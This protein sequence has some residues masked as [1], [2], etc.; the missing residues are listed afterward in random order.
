MG[1]IGTTAT[2]AVSVERSQFG[3]WEDDPF[4][5][6]TATW[7]D[8]PLAS[9]RP[10]VTV[11]PGAVKVFSS[12]SEHTAE[13][14]IERAETASPPDG[15]S[16]IACIPYCSRS[17]RIEIWTLFSGPT[18]VLLD[19]GKESGDYILHVFWRGTV[20]TVE[21]QSDPSCARGSE[22]FRFVFVPVPD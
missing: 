13:V 22:S 12:H 9:D 11:D 6:E 1:K 17:G 2:G 10:G 21:K 19:L 18:G 20:P 5:E 3:L 15:F 16:S 4:G 14:A 8:L 7:M